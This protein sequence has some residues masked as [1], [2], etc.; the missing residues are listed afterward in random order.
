VDE[1]VVA[2]RRIPAS[3]V[4][5][6][7]KRIV[8]AGRT[9]VYEGEAGEAIVLDYPLKI[10]DQRIDRIARLDASYRLVKLHPNSPGNPGYREQ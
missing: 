3:V 10:R 9:D 1:P 6:D 2:V 4:C 7:N 8:Y 5:C